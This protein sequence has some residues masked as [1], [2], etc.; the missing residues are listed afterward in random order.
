[1]KNA[2]SCI[3]VHFPNETLSLVCIPNSQEVSVPLSLEIDFLIESS[4]FPVLQSQR[5][6]STF[7]CF[8]D[9][10]DLNKTTDSIKH[11]QAYL[12][13]HG[14]ILT[15]SSLLQSEFIYFFIPYI[16]SNYLGLYKLNISD[17][18]GN[19]LEKYI[20]YLSDMKKCQLSLKEMYEECKNIQIDVINSTLNIQSHC[21]VLSSDCNRISDQINQIKC[22]VILLNDEFKELESIFEVYECTNCRSNFKDVL[23][24]PCGH[25]I[26]CSECLKLDY[27]ITVDLPIHDNS[28]SCGKCHQKVAQALK[29]SI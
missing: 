18:L 13:S 11:I 26:I 1:M 8:I 4:Y 7:T 3:V 25:I 12:T 17:L 9:T 28:L 15:A 27:H 6:D 2:T 14:Q 20:D 29:F 24:L 22:Q 5:L 16:N 23:Y 10:S 19:S 21:E